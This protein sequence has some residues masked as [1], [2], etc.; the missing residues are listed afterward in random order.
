MHLVPG[1]GTGRKTGTNREFPTGTNVRFSSS[2]RDHGE[3]EE[4]EDLEEVV[5]AGDE[6][7]QAAPGDLVLLVAAAGSQPRE[8]EVV[9]EVAGVPDGEDEHT[10][11]EQVDGGLWEAAVE[12]LCSR[13][14]ERLKRRATSLMWWG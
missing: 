9:V 1:S 14:A 10:R 12:A 4:R 6:L 7:E 8:E 5:R 11:V 13:K 2:V 3:P